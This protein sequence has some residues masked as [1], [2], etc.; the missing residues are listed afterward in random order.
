M[1]SELGKEGKGPEGARG[2]EHLL[3][4]VGSMKSCWS[5]GTRGSEL[6]REAVFT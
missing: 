6:E 3:R 4:S 1:D 2:H 5:W